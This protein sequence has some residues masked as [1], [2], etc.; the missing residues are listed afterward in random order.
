MVETGTK[1]LVTGSKKRLPDLD[2]DEESQDPIPKNK[3]SSNYQGQLN[4]LMKWKW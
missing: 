2:S 1:T 3:T 4:K